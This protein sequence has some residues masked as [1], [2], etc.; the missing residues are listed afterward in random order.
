MSGRRAAAENLSVGSQDVV[1]LFVGHLP[2]GIIL[3][4][5]QLHR[6][7]TGAQR[8][9]CIDEALLVGQ[10]H[11]PARHSMDCLMRLNDAPMP[12]FPGPRTLLVE[13]EQDRRFL[14][15]MLSPEATFV[16]AAMIPGAM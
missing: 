11:E 13:M 10:V 15:S 4:L 3:V 6:S 5:V 2:G 16:K 7:E 14:S 9:A 1:L 12:S 8:G